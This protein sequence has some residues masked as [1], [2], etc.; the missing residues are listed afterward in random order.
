MMGR[1]QISEGPGFRAD[2]GTP[3][4]RLRR[5][6]DHDRFCTTSRPDRVDGLIRL[7]PARTAATASAMTAGNANTTRIEGIVMVMIYPLPRVV[8]L[9]LSP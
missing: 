6:S 8:L 2:T 4:G 9:L 3:S 7:M 5:H 1:R